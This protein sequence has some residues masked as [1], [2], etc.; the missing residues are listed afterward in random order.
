MCS[1]VQVLPIQTFYGGGVVAWWLACVLKGQLEPGLNP[2]ACH[3]EFL[4]PLAPNCFLVYY[5]NGLTAQDKCCH[6]MTFK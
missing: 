4:R 5:G 2:K 6:N 1:W 3:S